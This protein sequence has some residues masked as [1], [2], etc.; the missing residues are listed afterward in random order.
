MISKEIEQEI[1]S[2]VIKRHGNDAGNKIPA[3]MIFKL[4]SE[5]HIR[6]NFAYCKISSDYDNNRLVGV[7]FSKRCPKDEL[8]LDIG[9]KI[10]FSRACKDYLSQLLG[11]KKEY[12]IC[13]DYSR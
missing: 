4:N 7:G 3:E 9:K 1:M 5:Y 8:V 10:A 6:G 11:D 13:I 2:T 12:N